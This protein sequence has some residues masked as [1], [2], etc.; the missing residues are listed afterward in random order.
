MKLYPAVDVQ[1]SSDIVLALVDDFLPS[2][3]EQGDAS[4]RVFFA[5]PDARDAACSELRCAGYRATPIDVSDEDWARRS[6]ENLKPITVGR[7]TVAP[8]WHVALEPGAPGPRDSSPGPFTIVIEPSMGFGTGHHATT[9]QC[10]EALQ[11]ID[12]AG[13]FVVDVG[14]GSGVLAIAADLLGCARALG[15][16]NDPDAIRSARDNLVLNPHAVR[17]SFETVDLTVDALPAADVVTAN[18]TG[19]L[20]TRAAGT[21][22]GALRD[23]GILVLSGIL[24]EE[25]EGVRHAFESTEPLWERQETEW[26]GLAL[27]KR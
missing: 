12:L 1:S 21:L 10:L 15:I 24:A 7:I 3:V 27:K 2:A 25:L 13:A 23:G 5:S 20:L 11:I 14:T 26:I 8:P 22:L 16:D 9:R 18:L 19:A 6:Q 17:T 4:M